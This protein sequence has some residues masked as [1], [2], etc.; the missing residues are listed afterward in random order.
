MKMKKIMLCICLFA[1]LAMTSQEKK[2][3]EKE[4]FKISKKIDFITKA[5]KDSLKVKVIAIES[6]LQKGEITKTKAAILKS[7]MAMYHAK[8]IEIKVGAQEILIQQLVQDKT[9]GKIVSSI[10]DAP[11]GNSFS[12]S[13]G[14]NGILF[15]KDAGIETSKVVDSSK[16]KR[17]TTQL[18]FAMGV[19]NV[20]QDHR[21][22]TLSD[23]EYKFWQSH[24]YE[25]GYSWKTRFAKETSQIYFKYGISFLWNNL[26]LDKNQIHIMLDNTVMTETFPFKLSESRLRHVQMNFPVHLE[27]NL[28]KNKKDKEGLVLDGIDNPFRLGIGGFVGF[29]LGTRQYL[30]YKDAAGMKREE[31]QYDNFDMNTLNYGLSAYVGYKMTSL[32]VKYDLNPLF[33]DTEMRNISMGIRFDLN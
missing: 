14:S 21:Q 22:T 13:I 3:F 10:K 6:K 18:V 17:T 29:K 4:I 11:L 8:Q 12:L 9:N 30:E 15:T 20:T 27:W 2:S 28:S 1:S 5:Q 33:R 16:K 26:R 32:Y 7:E 31:V 24:F 23:S 19:N 25:L